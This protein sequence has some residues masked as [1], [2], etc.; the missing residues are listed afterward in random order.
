MFPEEFW[1][2]AWR[3]AQRL[4]AHNCGNKLPFSQRGRYLAIMPM[5][6]GTVFTAQITA[7]LTI[8]LAASTVEDA[9]IPVPNNGFNRV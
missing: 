5:L 2:N 1:Q 3:T 8:S 9:P 6:G 4:I 7:L